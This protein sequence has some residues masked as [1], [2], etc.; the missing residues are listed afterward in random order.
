MGSVAVVDQDITLFED[1]IANNIKM[2]D[3]SIQD[4]EM[5]MAAQDAQL[6]DDITRLSHGYQHMLTS[7][8]FRIHDSLWHADGG[9]YGHFRHCAVRR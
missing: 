4:F 6:H 9:V 1:T 3:N 7:L 2:W 8:L 5:I